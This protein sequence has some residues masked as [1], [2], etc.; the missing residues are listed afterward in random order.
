MTTEATPCP[1]WLTPA[2]RAVYIACAH[3]CNH[4]MADATTDECRAVSDDAQVEETYERLSQCAFSGDVHG[5]QAAAQAYNAALR[6]ALKRVR[7]TP[8]G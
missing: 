4:T 7:E 5:T 6:A 3:I 2:Q 1:T 8:R